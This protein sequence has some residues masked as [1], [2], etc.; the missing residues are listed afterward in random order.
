LRWKK[1]FLLLAVVVFATAALLYYRFRK[2]P[3]HWN[4]FLATFTGVNWV[5]LS[6]SI[7][8]ILFTYVG[9]ALRWK[10]ML[11][12]LRLNASLWNINSATVIG[13]TAIFLLG[14][15]G[16]LVRPYLISLKERVPF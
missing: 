13:F 10:V 1:G 2:S 16:E 12:P 5:W 9:R 14:R 7:L 11:R 6:L 15:P 3:F 8:L 4:V